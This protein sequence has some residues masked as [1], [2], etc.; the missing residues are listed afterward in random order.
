MKWRQTEG[1]SNR[2][3]NTDDEIEDR[4]T[5]ENIHE[6]KA[7]SFKYINKTNISLVRSREKRHKLTMLMKEKGSDKPSH[8]EKVRSMC[9]EQQ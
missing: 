6:S 9:H 5:V 8:P 3:K 2:D 4:I 7:D 1:G